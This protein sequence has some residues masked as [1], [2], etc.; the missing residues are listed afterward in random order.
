MASTSQL[1][2]DVVFMRSEYPERISKYIKKINKLKIDF[3]ENVNYIAEHK[4]L[5]IPTFPFEKYEQIIADNKTNQQKV[6]A[7]L[8]EEI[9]IMRTLLKREKCSMAQL[10]R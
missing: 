9:I 2:E 1:Q 6:K 4:S 3:L 10:L 8:K 5:E 7:K